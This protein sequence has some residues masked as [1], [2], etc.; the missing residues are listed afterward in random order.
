MATYDSVVEQL[1]TAAKTRDLAEAALND[2][3]SGTREG[4][5]HHQTER[6][7]T[8]NLAVIATA[9]LTLAM[10]ETERARKD[11]TLTLGGP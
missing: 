3:L 9:L 11:G 4:E 7:C 2:I 5:Y 6:A 1:T 10:I 8:F